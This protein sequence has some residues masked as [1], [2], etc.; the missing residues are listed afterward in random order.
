[1]AI[2]SGLAASLGLAE[3]SVYGTYTAPTRHLEFSKEDLKKIKT[4]VQGGGLAAGR[5]AQLGSR[6]VLTTVS[7]GGTVDLEVTNKGYGLI[8]EHL[9]GSSATAVQQAA[10]T[11]YLQ[12]HTIG[13]N[14]GK[15]L[16]VQKGVPDTGGTVRPYT[17][18]GGK[19]TGAT[20]QCDV[21]GTLMST[22][23][24]DFKDVSEA[25]ALAA[26]SYAA[27][28]APFHGGQMVVKLGT[29]GAET[30]ITGVKKIE[31]KI[32]RP[33][34]NERFYAS[35][36]G[37]PATKSE[38]IMNDYLSVSGTLEADYVTKADLAD[39]FASDASTSLVIEWIGPI[40]AST[41]AETFRIKVPMI[42]VD[43]DTPGV[44]GP[45]VVSTPYS[46]T[47]QSDGTNPVVAIDY[48]S[49]DTAP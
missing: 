11:A 4:T 24:F 41:Y 47:G 34:A 38:P 13:D 35:A 21:L 12:A 18:L 28:V 19:I 43:S 22:V 40:I 8:I 46:F 27:G 36:A 25:Q 42:F 31:V 23:E 20:F 16:S 17:F 39:R 1:M 44:E 2:G 26:P 29:Y 30:A 32:E 9:L 33:Q 48:M 45:D 14:I 6:R 7:G 37:S 10:T 15:Y 3:E 49:T 5:F